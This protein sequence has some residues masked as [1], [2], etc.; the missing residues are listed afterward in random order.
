MGRTVKLR[1]EQLRRM[2]KH[3]SKEFRGLEDKSHRREKVKKNE[4]DEVKM[5]LVVAIETRE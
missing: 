1:N 2:V 4:M 5:K 3:F